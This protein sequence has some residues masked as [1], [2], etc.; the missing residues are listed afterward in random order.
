MVDPELRFSPRLAPMA[1]ATSGYRGQ[2]VRIMELDRWPATAMED[3]SLLSLY[4][5]MQARL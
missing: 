4:E 2:H 1:L 5:T 3:F